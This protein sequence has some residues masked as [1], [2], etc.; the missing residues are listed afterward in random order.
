MSRFSRINLLLVALVVII[1]AAPLVLGLGRGE[2]PFSGADAQAETGI[3]EVAPA[4]EPWF[5][6]L[7]EPPSGEVE[8]GLFALQ[9]ALGAG[10][11][12]YC[13]GVVRTRRRLQGERD[14]VEDPTPPESDRAA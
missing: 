7:F 3:T 11:L 2:E 4:Y 5:S 9:A 8:S 14:D 10:V 1:V 13:F 12:G 6:S